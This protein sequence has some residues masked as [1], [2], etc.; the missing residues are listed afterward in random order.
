MKQND[1]CLKTVTRLTERRQTQLMLLAWGVFPVTASARLPIQLASSLLG[2]LLLSLT[3]SQAHR[4]RSYFQS[5]TCLRIT[6]LASALGRAWTKTTCGA[7]DLTKVVPRT[8]PCLALP[9]TGGSMWLTRFLHFF[10][11]IC[12][13]KLCKFEWLFFLGFAEK[14][15]FY[16]NL[17]N[18]IHYCYLSKYEK[19]SVAQASSTQ[20]PKTDFLNFVYLGREFLICDP[21]TGT[22][23]KS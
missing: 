3:P 18:N 12:R 8:P 4:Q 17:I 6:H 19:V 1:L 23:F 20:S 21:N 16:S 2:S 22:C 9:H 11:Y 15:K 13:P 10:K 7:P 14:K 5:N